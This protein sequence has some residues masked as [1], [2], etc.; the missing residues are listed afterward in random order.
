MATLVNV[1][2]GLF[3]ALSIGALAYF[4]HKA[5]WLVRYKNV[6]RDMMRDADAQLQSARADALPRWDE[7]AATA[8]RVARGPKVGTGQLTS[9]AAYAKAIEAELQATVEA[10]SKPLST[11]PLMRA[12]LTAEPSSDNSHVIV[13]VTARDNSQLRAQL[14]LNPPAVSHPEAPDRELYRLDLA[15]RYG[16]FRRALVFVTGL[17]DVVYSAHHIAKMS[18]YTHI[19][20]GTIIRRLALV[21]LLVVGIVL[22]VVL[23]MRGKLEHFLQ[24]RVLRGARWVDKLPDVIAD[25]LP[26]IIA[27]VAWTVA[28]ATAYFGLYFAVRRR[29]KQHLEALGRLEAQQQPRLAAIRQEHLEHLLRWARDYGRTLNTAVQ[30]T[31]HHV[32]LLAQHYAARLRGRISGPLLLDAAQRMGDVL[33]SRL[34]EATGDLQDHVTTKK[35]S[36]AHALWPRRQEMEDVVAQTQ[37]RAAWQHIE[38][39]LG[40]LR[41][42]LADPADVAQFWRHLV[43]YAVTFDDIFDDSTLRQLQQSHLKLVEEVSNETDGDLQRFD[44]RLRDQMSH[45]DEQLGAAAHLLAARVELTNQNIAADAAKLQAEIIRCREAARLEAMAFEI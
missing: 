38:L 24:R 29:S 39:T 35:R 21:V 27:F 8:W 6:Q 2:S 12:V 28:V 34:P 26:A 31:T 14:T 3:V 23:G 37:Y 19:P 41:R 25:D 32:E 1:V 17:A 40:E 7:F 9:P 11:V 45:L 16:F 4:I 43:S 44:S 5:V 13:E 33:L 42:G 20:K 15:S 22:E 10:L 30:L 18:Q 36:W